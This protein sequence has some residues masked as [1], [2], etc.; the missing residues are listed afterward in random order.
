MIHP[1]PVGA[2]LSSV[3][4]GMGDSPMAISIKD[5]LGELVDR[6]REN[7]QGATADSWVVQG[8]NTTD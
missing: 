2:C 6:F 5:G 7:G 4:K 1:A 8:P 3:K